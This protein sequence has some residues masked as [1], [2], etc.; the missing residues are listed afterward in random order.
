MHLFAYSKPWEKDGSLFSLKC[1]NL[2]LYVF[3]G[4]MQVSLNYKNWCC[5]H[6]IDEPPT[7]W[8]DS[9]WIITLIFFFIFSFLIVAVKFRGI[10]FIS[11]PEKWVVLCTLLTYFVPSSVKG[12]VLLKTKVLVKVEIVITAFNIVSM[13][14]DSEM[15][16][17]Y[18]HMISYWINCWI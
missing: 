10:F 14:T 6:M 3:S 8:S 15:A 18:Q 11:H 2:T 7:Y 12:I 4:H 5:P 17:D 9:S 1:A 13:F 16:C